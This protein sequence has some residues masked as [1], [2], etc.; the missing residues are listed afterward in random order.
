ME[1][2]FWGKKN[3][4][5]HIFPLETNFCRE[6]D[7]V[8]NKR[9]F[10]LSYNIPPFSV[11]KGVRIESQQT[12]SGENS[13]FTLMCGTP[14]WGGIYFDRCFFQALVATSMH[15][16]YN[17]CVLKCCSLYV[18]PSPFQIRIREMFPWREHERMNGSKNYW[19]DY[20][21]TRIR[22]LKIPFHFTLQKIT[23]IPC[24]TNYLL[25]PNPLPFVASIHLRTKQN[26]DSQI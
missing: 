15:V 4:G 25:N 12:W 13:P 6:V 8:G 7:I 10:Q 11:G 14:L 21:N 26:P 23:I 18:S 20:M 1:R 22:K 16:W 5:L 24:G 3:I 2:V 19:D 9:R 17:E